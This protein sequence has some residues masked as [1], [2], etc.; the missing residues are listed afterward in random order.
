MAEG[1][2]SCHPGL[3]RRW[4]AALLVLGVATRI[5]WV[6]WVHPPQAH[7]RSDMAAYVSQAR[8]IATMGEVAAH[9]LPGF[10]PFGMG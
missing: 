4:L 6:V 10:R 3:D 1:N 7:V 2:R 8:D 5:A 9:R